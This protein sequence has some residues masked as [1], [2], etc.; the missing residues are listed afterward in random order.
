MKLE[1][2]IFTIMN[3][4]LLSATH[5][6][7]KPT[8]EQFSF[9]TDAFFFQL[10]ENCSCL[11]TGIGA[12]QTAISLTKH[13]SKH[14]YDQVI[15]VGIAG[16]YDRTLPLGNVVEVLSD[17]YGDLGVEE[18][19]GS[20]LS[21]PQIGLSLSPALD[22]ELFSWNALFPELKSVKSM[23][24]NLVA[25]TNETIIKRAKQNTELETMEGIAAALAT[26]EFKIPFTQ[27]RSIS[28]Y[29]EPRNKANWN[30][31]LALKNLNEFVLQKIIQS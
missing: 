23:T 21:L 2:T 4:L 19:D 13:L 30:V 10:T 6:E 5:L 22:N 26:N 3:T 24:V 16:S 1:Q 25:G 27:L 12:I 15:Q 31:P 14:K 20:Y 8:L 29:V 7:I 28:N 9:K 17:K 11:I 18:K